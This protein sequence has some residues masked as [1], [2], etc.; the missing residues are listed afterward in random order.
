[1][2]RRAGTSTRPQIAPNLFDPQGDN[3]IDAGGTMR[4]RSP[5]SVR[6]RQ[7]QRRAC[8]RD[9]IVSFDFKELAGNQR[10][11]SSDRSPMTSPRPTWRKAPRITMAMTLLRLAPTATRIRSLGCDARRCRR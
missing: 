7:Q 5:L 1:M 9:G 2:T 4:G 3:G 8:K 6:M 10:P 11:A